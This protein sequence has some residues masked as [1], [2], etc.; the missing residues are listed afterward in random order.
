[1]IRNLIIHCYPRLSGKWRRTLAHLTAGD[2]WSQFNGR[3]IVAVAHD[4]CTEH[5]NDVVLAWWDACDGDPGVE[6]IIQPNVQGLQEVATFLPLMEEIKST[7]D[8]EFTTRIHTKGCTQPDG[9]GSHG[10]LDLMAFANL[11][12]PRL[13]ECCFWQGANIAGAFR[14]HGLWAFPGYH[15]WHYA[16]TWF[17]FRHSRIFGELDW[18]NIHPNFMGV[19][20]WPGIV[21]LAESAC[22]FYDNA[23]TAHLYSPEFQR[24]NLRPALRYWQQN[25]AKCG[26]TPLSE[27]KRKLTEAIA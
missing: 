27:C 11:D 4:E 10:W 8:D 15:N 7:R 26:L 22:L 18:R 13:L 17:T 19:E 2:R 20:A 21:P 5:P 1:M 3:K 23:N 14:S 25:L 9:H 24:D 12:Y 16:G 6:W